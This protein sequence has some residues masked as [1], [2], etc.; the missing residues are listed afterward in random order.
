MIEAVCGFFFNSEH[1]QLALIRKTKP[2]WQRGK[3]NGIG[4][5][6]E[7]NEGRT[8]AMVREFREETGHDT[9]LTQWTRYFVLEDLANGYRVFY[10]RTTGDLGLLR[11]ME[12]EQVEIC[13]L[14]QLPELPVIHNLRWLIPMAL[15]T[16]FTNGRGEW[17]D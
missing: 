8:A 4:G 14:V 11:T 17:V 3:L 13:N 10:F 16:T 2:A 15:D 12:E 9:M 1:T 7:P 6:I 5:K